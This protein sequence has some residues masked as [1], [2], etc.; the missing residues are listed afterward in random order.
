MSTTFVIVRFTVMPA[1]EITGAPAARSTWR[2][3]IVRSLR[4]FAPA[5]RMYSSPST[6]RTDV[7]VSRMM[8]AASGSPTSTHGTTSAPAQPSALSRNG[9]YVRGMW[10]PTSTSAMSLPNSRISPSPTT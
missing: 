5:A 10:T 7:R 3:R 6:D 1:A 4:P 2:R 9:T 8:S